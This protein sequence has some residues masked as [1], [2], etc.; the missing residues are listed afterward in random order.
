HG[1]GVQAAFWEDPRVLTISLHE[2]PAT[3]FPQ[4][5]ASPRRSRRVCARRAP[6][7][8]RARP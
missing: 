6:P 4:T 5:R 7:R 3:L 2:H 1:D 8:G